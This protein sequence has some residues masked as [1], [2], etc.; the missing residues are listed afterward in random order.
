MQKRDADDDANELGE[1]LTEKLKGKK[2]EWENKMG[3]MTCILQECGILDG[4]KKFNPKKAKLDWK[5]MPIKDKW[6]KDELEWACD[7]CEKMANNIPKPFLE[8]SP[9]GTE[10]CKVKMFKE[11]MMKVKFFT[12]MKSDIRKKLEKH[13]GD[14]GELAKSTDLTEDQLLMVVKTLLKGPEEEFM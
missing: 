3:N 13:F 7:Q 9:F 1:R 2:E 6:V 4:A 5:D 12:C 8:K 14:V 10:M 11:C